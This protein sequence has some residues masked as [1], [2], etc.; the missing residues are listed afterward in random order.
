[1]WH[2]CLTNTRYN[3]RK[4][5]A[6]VLQSLIALLRSW[7]RPEVVEGMRV[8]RRDTDGITE[9]ET[10]ERG[11]GE[12]RGVSRRDYTTGGEREHTSDVRAE[13]R[14]ESAAP[15]SGRKLRLDATALSPDGGHGA[16][17]A[18]G[19]EVRGG[20]KGSR[21]GREQRALEEMLHKREGGGSVSRRRMDVNA[22]VT[23]V[24]RERCGRW[25]LQSRA[26]ARG[27]VSASALPSPPI[28]SPFPSPASPGSRPPLRSGVST[29]FPPV[30]SPCQ[31]RVHDEEGGGVRREEAPPTTWGG[32]GASAC[33]R[34][35]AKCVSCPRRPR[36]E[37]EASRRRVFPPSP[38]LS[39]L[40]CFARGLEHPHAGV[41]VVRETDETEAGGSEACWLKGH[42]RTSVYS[43][44][45]ARERCEVGRT[46]MEEGEGGSGRAGASL[47]HR[48]WWYGRRG[49]RTAY[50]PF[51]I[52]PI[53]KPDRQR[54]RPLHRA[55]AEC[56]G[57]RTLL[58]IRVHFHLHP[59]P[60]WIW[61]CIL[62]LGQGRA[63]E[64]Q[65]RVKGRTERLGEVPRR[66]DRTLGRDEAERKGEP[67]WSKRRTRTRVRADSTCARAAGAAGGKEGRRRWKT[68]REGGGWPGGK[69]ARVA[70]TGDGR[71]RISWCRPPHGTILVAEPARRCQACLCGVGAY[72]EREGRRRAR[73]LPG[74]SCTSVASSSWYRTRR[75]AGARERRGRSESDRAAEQPGGG[76]EDAKTGK[77]RGADGGADADAR[78][79]HTFPT[80][81]VTGGGPL[82]AYDARAGPSALVPHSRPARRRLVRSFGWR[83]LCAQSRPR[84]DLRYNV[85]AGSMKR[86]EEARGGK[87]RE[88]AGESCKDQLTDVLSVP[89]PRALPLPYRTVLPT[90]SAFVPAAG[91]SY[92]EG[93]QRAAPSPTRA[94]RVRAMR[95]VGGGVGS[96]RVQKHPMSTS[97]WQRQP[98]R[99]S[100][101]LALRQIG[102]RDVDEV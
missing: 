33:S 47:P 86:M 87:E 75:N 22:V 76:R 85:S 99:A 15:V 14:K 12:G 96:V 39:A 10:E 16:D 24:S 56:A 55:S 48:R 34:L 41:R 21:K 49:H 13:R 28:V 52:I 7:W 93:D 17:G 77:D 69:Q 23:S 67:R 64:M 92:A 19:A 36:E 81:R 91:V 65:M 40:R 44:W 58:L 60:R 43:V 30:C 100:D 27:A 53:V 79:M 63:V 88:R 98:N 82:Q 89:Y 68:K 74:P 20:G 70:H 78:S 102:I 71:R 18:R 54:P 5:R 73:I 29:P 61:I 84:S 90:L 72:E 83:R 35:Y 46:K 8:W 4:S 80:R 51:E 94:R 42:A 32:R 45:P 2:L 59:T 31:R 37:G 38:A 62:S 26:V 25:R 95:D 6:R 9:G 3:W 101:V 1:M 11:D 50:P 57:G 97:G 66:D